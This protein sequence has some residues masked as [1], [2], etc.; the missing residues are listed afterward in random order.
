MAWNDPN[1][2][3]IASNG[4]VYVA[5]V[6]TALPTTPIAAL[7]PA[8]VGLGYLTTDG[9]TIAVSPEI[10]DI[11]SWQ[12]RQATRREL[13]SQEVT[14]NF[15]LQQF[16]ESTV[17]FAFGGG[18][19]TSPST[20]IYRYELPTEGALDERCLVI[21]AIDG[22]VHQRWILPRGNVTDAVEM[23]FVRDAEQQLP[24]AFKG[25]QPS[26]GSTSLIL[27]TDDAAAYAAGS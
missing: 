20:G 13:T 11:N 26:D 21:D 27:L 14:A 23:K 1:E 18:E 2:I 16:N 8:F 15:V 12:S 6:G 4:E 25:L 17:P 3:R 22:P 24:I 7:D 9:V 10:Q 19:V 5:P